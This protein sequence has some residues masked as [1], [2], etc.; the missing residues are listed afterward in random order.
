MTK[1]RITENPNTGAI[2]FSFNLNE[3]DMSVVPEQDAVIV[4]M[5]KRKEDEQIQLSA[6][7]QEHQS[8]QAGPTQADCK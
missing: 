8:N 4:Q 5:P 3:D 1:I 7:D 2:R 6:G